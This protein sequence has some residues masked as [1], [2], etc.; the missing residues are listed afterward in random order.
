MNNSRISAKITEYE[1]RLDRYVMDLAEQIASSART[2]VYQNLRP[3]R[4]SSPL[5]NSPLANSIQVRNDPA[6]GNKTGAM[7]YTTM[8]YARY[9]EFG[10]RFQASRPFLTPAVEEVKVSFSGFLE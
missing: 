9:V 4:A 3:P 8:P 7:V 6:I 5:A 2:K 10:T 1:Q